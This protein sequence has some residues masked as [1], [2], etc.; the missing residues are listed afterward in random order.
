MYLLGVRSNAVYRQRTTPVLI[1]VAGDSGAGK[2]TLGQLLEQL[3][4]Q[5][6]VTIINGDDYHRWPRGHEKWQ[7]YT[8]LNIRG[9]QVHKQ[10]Q[11][12]VA[13]H[14]GRSIV[15]GVYDHATGQFTHPQEIDPNEYIVFSGLHALALDNMRRMFDLKVFLDPDEDL[16]RQWK[17]RR[18]QAERGYDPEQV[19][20]QLEQRQPDRAAYILPQRDLADLVLR[21]RPAGTN[22]ALELEVQARNGY[23]LTGVAEALGQLEGVAVDLQPFL[24]GHWQRLRLMGEAGSEPLRTIAEAEVPNLVEIAPAPKFASGVNGMMQL[25]VLACLSQRLR[26]GAPWAGEHA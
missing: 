17:T 24:D 16:R 21:L 9:S 5:R 7:V 26:W 25:A 10:A 3:L 2:T 4:G 19:A 18:D 20:A 1:G 12:A 14:A 6:R 8:H 13:M 15:K 22:G 11:H 23:D